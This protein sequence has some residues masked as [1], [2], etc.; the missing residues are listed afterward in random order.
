MSQLKVQNITTKM[1]F[2]IKS[3]DLRNQSVL[4]EAIR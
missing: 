4:T 2:H 3:L 1:K